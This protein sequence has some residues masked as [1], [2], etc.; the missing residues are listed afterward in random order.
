MNG[1]VD[2]FIAPLCHEQIEVLFADEHILLINK[3]SGLLSLSGK[4]PLNSDSVH[5]RLVHLY[6]SALMTHRL[7]FGTSGLM[8][9]ALNKTVNA[10]ITKQFQDRTIIKSYESILYGH[11]EEDEGDI[12]I[13][14]L[15]DPANF[16]RQ[17]V[18][19]VS[20]KQALSHYT[21]LERLHS[22]ARTRVRF[23]PLTGRTHQLRVHSQALGHPILGCD[24]YGTDNI[25][26]SDISTHS[27]AKR[28]LLHAL[29]LDFVHPVSAQRISRK[30]PCP[31]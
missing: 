23:T 25:N 9:L 3:P 6:P 29:T 18:C 28:L 22:P 21:V 7:D 15:K 20:G 24:L 17:K 27:M 5:R 14:I 12:D 16:P 1:I 13:P 19:H 26:Q 10:H 30:C 31:F 11:V 8:L 4:N 2:T